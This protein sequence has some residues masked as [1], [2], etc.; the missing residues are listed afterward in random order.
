MIGSF[1]AAAVLI[2]TGRRSAALA[3]AGVGLAALASDHPEKLQKIWDV[4]PDYIEKGSRLVNEVGGLVEKIAEKGS[5]LQSF[6]QGLAT[7]RPDYLT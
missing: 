3:A 4:A 7:S 6:R 5:R 1:A 2:F